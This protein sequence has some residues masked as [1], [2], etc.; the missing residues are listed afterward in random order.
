VLTGRAFRSGK[1]ILTSE[2]AATARKVA[3]T[4]YKLSKFYCDQW[5]DSFGSQREGTKR[6]VNSWWRIYY[7]FPSSDTGRAYAVC[8]DLFYWPIAWYGPDSWF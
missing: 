5:L 3:K 6:A 8:E 2:E 4:T 1:K 7:F